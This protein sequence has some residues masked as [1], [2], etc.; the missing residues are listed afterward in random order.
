MHAPKVSI[1]IPTFNRAKELPQ[2]IESAL[3]QDYSN[4]EVIVSD[5]ASIDET[6]LVVKKYASDDRFKYYRN[7]QNIGMSAN[8]RRAVFTHAS[9][10]WALIL[11][12][13]DYLTDPTYIT[14]TMR[15]AEKFKDIVIIH[16][17]YE[18]SVNNSYKIR[19]KKEI[20]EVVDGKWMFMNYDKRH[21]QYLLMTT[22]FHRKIAK[23]LYFFDADILYPD[24]AAF[25]KISLH[26]KA[27]F[28]HDYVGVYRLHET[29]AGKCIDMNILFDNL[30]AITIPYEYAKEK[31]I[32][33]SI[34]LERWK[35][36]MIKNSAN[37]IL[38]KIFI[39]RKHKDVKELYRRL[40]QKYP[41]ALF[42]FLQ[43]INILKLFTFRIPY[44]YNL[45][46]RC[47]KTPMK[48]R[49]IKVG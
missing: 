40:K 45:L 30:Q 34:E 6:S 10:E 18:V 9:G 4:L 24:L 12:D 13:D 7:I 14:K 25:L 17:N 39:S 21:I 15:L 32:F 2:A 36:R 16:A 19:L 27:G 33:S 28:I 5:N 3:A 23:E 8:W 41:F 22:I 37:A 35:R 42:I 1:L 43:P 38:S 11:S 47:H 26:G 46:K 29:N 49:Q 44:L 31:N 48:A 20:P